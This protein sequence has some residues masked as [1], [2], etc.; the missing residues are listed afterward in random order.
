MAFHS[1]VVKLLLKRRNPDFP[2][3]IPIAPLQSMELHS[4]LSS[5]SWNL[6]WL[7]FHMSLYVSIITESIYSA[8]CFCKKHFHLNHPQ[9]QALI[10]LPPSLS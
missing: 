1:T 5:I 8:V 3:I 10:L 4:H 2:S 9:P 7:I 6:V